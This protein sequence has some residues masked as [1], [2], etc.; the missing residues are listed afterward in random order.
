MRQ[1]LLSEQGTITVA[2][3]PGPTAYDSDVSGDVVWNNELQQGYMR[4]C[5]DATNNASLLQYQ[6]WIIDPQRDDE[7]I[8]G[9][10]F[11]IN[12]TGEVFVPISA[13]LKVILLPLLRLQKKSQVALSCLHKTSCRCLQKS[14]EVSAMGHWVEVFYD[15]DCPLCLREIRVL[16]WFDKTRN[17]I[18]FTDISASDF[19]AANYGKQQSDLMAEIHGRMPNGDWIIG[20]EVF[21]QLYRAIGLGPLVWISRMPG[22]SHLLGI[23]YSFFAKYRLPLTGR[24][25][26]DGI[27]KVDGS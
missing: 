16:Q 1:A 21:R 8:D 20:V 11:D 2:W 3:S 26:Q 27:C 5:W 10:V 18:L 17:R 4:F 12:S 25:A 19:E 23:G 14:S 22:L 24:C 15:G 7:P 6:L 13:K 9:G